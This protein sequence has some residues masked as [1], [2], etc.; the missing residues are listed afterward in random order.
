MEFLKQALNTPLVKEDFHKWVN[1]R[2]IELRLQL[3]GAVDPHI[4]YR[5]QGQ[6]TAYKRMERLRDE[7]NGRETS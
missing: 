7:L 3:E 1:S 5:L 6:L 2:I 4:I